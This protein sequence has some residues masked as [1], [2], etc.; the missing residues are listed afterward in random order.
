[1]FIKIFGWDNLS[2]FWLILIFQFLIFFVVGRFCFEFVFFFWVVCV[3]TVLIG[4]FCRLHVLWYVFWFFW[5][6][7][8]VLF[9]SGNDI[10]SLLLLLFELCL[11]ENFMIW[12]GDLIHR[13]FLFTHL[14]SEKIMIMKNGIMIQQICLLCHL[15]C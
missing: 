3:Y 13:I 1:M 6:L 10:E 9:V 4:F 2:G 14:I 5:L 15:M 12:W 8:P 7:S 11:V